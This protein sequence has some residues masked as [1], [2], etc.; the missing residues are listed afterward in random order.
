MLATWWIWIA[1]AVAL[2]IVELLLPSFIFLGFAIGA[3]VIG[4]L[5]LVGGPLAVMLSGSVPLLLVLFGM[6]SL[7][8]W[9]V[10]RRVVGVRKGQ[11]RIVDRDIN[12]D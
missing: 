8:S 9:I 1:F 10:V 11:V 7:I 12:S 4:L 2:G 5:L 3:A 6:V